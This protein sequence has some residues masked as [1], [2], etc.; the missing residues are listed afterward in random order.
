MAK[1]VDQTYRPIMVFTLATITP[2]TVKEITDHFSGIFNIYCVYG[3]A[4][5][6]RDE[7][8]RSRIIDGNRFEKMY[9]DLD[10]RDPETANTVFITSY[11]TFVR[12]FT[13][14]KKDVPYHQLDEVERL[15][16]G[17]VEEPADVFTK[18]FT[19][20]RLN[21]PL[22]VGLLICDEAHVIKN[23]SVR[24]HLA[25]A[26][27]VAQARIMSSATPLLNRPDDVIAYL[28][29]GFNH[30]PKPPTP[31]GWP[32]AKLYSDSLDPH[33]KIGTQP[34]RHYK[35]DKTM[36]PCPMPGPCALDDGDH[37][38]FRTIREAFDTHGERLWLFSPHLYRSTAAQG[39]G[40]YTHYDTALRYIMQ[41]FCI[42][43]DM[44][45]AIELPNGKICT[46][47][48][49]IPA[50]HYITKQLSLTG[51]GKKTHDEMLDQILPYLYKQGKVGDGEADAT[52]GTGATS[53]AGA[54]APVKKI[55]HGAWRMSD[56]LAIN[57]NDG[58]LLRLGEWLRKKEEA[59]KHERNR[60]TD[61]ARRL[62]SDESDDQGEDQDDQDNQDGHVA[63]GA[64]ETNALIREHGANEA[65]YMFR[66]T[67]GDSRVPVPSSRI[68]LVSALVRQ[69]A[70]A[71]AAIIEAI[72]II[73]GPREYGLPN[74]LVV[75]VDSPW[76]QL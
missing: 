38:G 46:P 14:Q 70:V 7:D 71:S 67:A 62:D 66:Q 34:Y 75:M 19:L 32:L 47:G 36:K 73:Q 13:Y 74:R 54:R 16:L 60:R 55:D 28:S 5:H 31:K 11:M 2:Q 25:I 44:D 56:L 27:I 10:P 15:H 39:G 20:S 76:T 12:R 59:K 58:K 8:L 40:A 42:R 64:A 51:E 53:G 1:D 45:T 49:D 65:G 57:P 22:H 50:A 35:T 18:R 41:Y 30:I 72:E 68:E 61:N 21:F 63:L 33:A 69:S 17:L 26:S 29:L 37:P 4:S 48:D 9:R 23:V 3:T 6:E 43:R 24:M 52:P